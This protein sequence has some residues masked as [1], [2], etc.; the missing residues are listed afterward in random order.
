[1]QHSFVFV[2]FDIRVQ[3]AAVELQDARTALCRALLKVQNLE[4][5]SMGKAYQK[6]LPAGL[7]NAVLTIIALNACGL[8]MH[9]S[10][11]C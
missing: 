8:G 4:K 3:A 5:E 2:Q 7:G 11:S 6:L 9:E 10:N 1:M